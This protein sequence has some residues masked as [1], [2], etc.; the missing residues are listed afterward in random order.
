[1]VTEGLMVIIACQLA[2]HIGL[3]PTCTYIT[4]NMKSSD[5]YL[6]LTTGL[7]LASNARSA[8]LAAK[9]NA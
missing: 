6:L 7:E 1:M 8:S 5:L 9:V 4:P 3:V 2:S